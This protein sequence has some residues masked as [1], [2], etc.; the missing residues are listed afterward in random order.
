MNTQDTPLNRPFDSAGFFMR[1]YNAAMPGNAVTIVAEVFIAI[2]ISLTIGKVVKAGLATSIGLGIFF[3]GY[4]IAAEGFLIGPI[5]FCVVGA[6]VALFGGIVF[7]LRP[8]RRK[9]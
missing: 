4:E 8:R 3:L 2:A 1:W 5:E 9:R 7:L 6:L